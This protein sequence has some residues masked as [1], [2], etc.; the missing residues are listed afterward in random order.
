MVSL[1]LSFVTVNSRRAELLAEAARQLIAHAFSRT[2]DDHLGSARE[3]PQ[4][5]TQAPLLI[6]RIDHLHVLR[7]RLVRHQII[8]VADEHVHRALR[9]KLLGDLAHL[10]GPG[11]T[12]E[13]RLPIRWD[14]SHNF[15]NL[16]LETHV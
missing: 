11:G 8:R 13:D 12:V 3:R 15:L 5:L 2:E 4:D 16:R 10:L 14:Q 9:D 6:H 7:D 1:A